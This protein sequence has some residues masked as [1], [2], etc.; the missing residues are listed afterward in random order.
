VKEGLKWGEQSKLL[1]A[2]YAMMRITPV[3]AALLPVWVGSTFDPTA[4]L[5]PPAG[6]AAV[7]P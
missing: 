5:A 1:A 3:E 2:E 4:P 6:A 7:G